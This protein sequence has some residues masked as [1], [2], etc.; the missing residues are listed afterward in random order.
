MKITFISLGVFSEKLQRKA[1]CAFTQL[2]L[3]KTGKTH[4]VKVKLVKWLC[5]YIHVLESFIL[6]NVKM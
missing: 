4:P 3:R 6:Q 1:K 2:G 5:V